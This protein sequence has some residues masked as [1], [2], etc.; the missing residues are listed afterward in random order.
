MTASKR[1]V[2]VCVQTGASRVAMTGQHAWVLAN[3]AF[4]QMRSVGARILRPIAAFIFP[5]RI[6]SETELLWI[7]R[8][9]LNA[10]WH[11]RYQLLKHRP[12]NLA[13]YA[14]LGLGESRQANHLPHHLEARNERKHQSGAFGGRLSAESC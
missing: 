1:S 13:Q 2:A 9:S 14:S 10:R 8:F 12:E 6:G 7:I 3:R 4:R 5:V 11:I